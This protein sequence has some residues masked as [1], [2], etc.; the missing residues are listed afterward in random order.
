LNLIDPSGLKDLSDTVLDWIARH[1]G[2]AGGV[3]GYSESFSKLSANTDFNAW[4]RQNAQ[5]GNQIQAG[6]VDM[7][8]SYTDSLMTAP[9]SEPL[10]ELSGPWGQVL[11]GLSDVLDQGGLF[12]SGSPQGAGQQYDIP[13]D[14]L[15]AFAAAVA[16][17]VGSGVAQTAASGDP[18]QLIG[19]AGYAQQNWVL[20]GSLLT[21]QILFENETNA[22][23]PAQNV[24]ITDPLSTNLNWSTIALTEIAFGN[25]SILVPQGS[26][27]FQTNVPFSFNG[28]DFE[29]QI[30]AGI[31]L[32]N[33]QVFADFASI[34]PVTSLPPAVNIGFLP[35]EDGT[36]RG[37]GQVSYTVQPKPNLA[38]GTRIPNVA[39]V[40]FDV[41][42]VIA[43]D[44]VNDDN[45]SLGISTNKQAIVTIDSAPPASSV[46][47]LPPT[48][49][50][51]SFSVCWS[52]TDV[53]PGIVGYDIYVSTNGGPWAPW[54]VGT[55][56]TCA[57]FTGQNGM[58]YGFYSVAHDGAGNIEVKSPAAEAFTTV[59][60]ATRPR[61]LSG[62]MGLGGV[63]TITFSSAP[64][65]TNIVQASSDLSNWAP[66]ETITNS[67]GILQFQDVDASNHRERFYRIQIP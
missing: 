19:P 17:A 28:V 53:G 29:V 52:G 20:D 44:Q 55:T 47:S 46:S 60:A 4:S 26:Q 63:F 48:E 31:N 50:S 21:Y 59:Q 11:G 30:Q 3:K 66:L 40:Q 6:A 36:G 14:A 9:V 33:G 7:F 2:V 5:Y 13:S 64:G 61:I 34:D 22:T 24:A 37:M 15:D 27:Y 35:P 32:A 25:T 51:A 10:Q 23:A 49:T 65:T 62:D 42:P 18:N 56:N 45:P 1:W 38:N 39:Y 8:S 58:S 12:I 41:N 57:A 16:Q 67:T 43:T 54:L